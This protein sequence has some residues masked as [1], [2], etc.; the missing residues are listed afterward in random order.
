MTS[1]STEGLPN[2]YSQGMVASQARNAVPL[3]QGSPNV[4]TVDGTRNSPEPAPKLNREIYVPLF[5]SDLSKNVEVEDEQ[6]TAKKKVDDHCT[7]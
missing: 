7:R 1:R 2:R 3:G 5:Q 4:A 6:K